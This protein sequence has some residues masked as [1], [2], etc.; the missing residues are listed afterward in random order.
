[1]DIF[2][3]IRVDK[4]AVAVSGNS[5]DESAV[6]VSE[7]SSDESAVVEESEGHVPNW[8]DWHPEGFN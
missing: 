8:R 5:G 6:S 4:S 2:A 7:N 1:M 3:I